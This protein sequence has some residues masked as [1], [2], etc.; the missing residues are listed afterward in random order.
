MNQESNSQTTILITGASGFIGS[1]LVEEALSRGMNVIAGVRPSS[2]KK[3]LADARITFLELNFTSVA[4]MSSALAEAA[5]RVGKI[6]YVIHNAGITKAPKEEDYIE[7]NA[8]FTQNFLEAL[9]QAKIK[10]KKF[11]YMSSLAAYGPGDPLTREPIKNEH[12]PAPLTA[13]GK[14][15]LQAEKIL[16]SG[17]EIPWVI[18]RPTAVFGPREKEIFALFK[19]IN[20][21]LHPWISVKSQK[22]S[23]IYVK[24]LAR[25]VLDA[26]ISPLSCKSYFISDG[27]TYTGNVFGEYV[28]KAM[29][30]RALNIPVSGGMMKII[31]RILGL[32]ASITGKTPG[33]NSEKA[34]ELSSINWT[35]DISPAVSDLNFKPRYTL[36]SAIQETALWYKKEGWI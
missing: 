5:I 32:I 18:I 10:P 31:A 28:K 30:K 35:C 17:N 33:L 25:V 19:I 36:E 4:A 24:D 22:L 11:V 34:V 8:R 15:K 21:H 7:I 6:D 20:F 9:I 3:F 16:M 12:I 2:S 23:F 14:S 1:F 27:Q 29:R 13:Y 26:G